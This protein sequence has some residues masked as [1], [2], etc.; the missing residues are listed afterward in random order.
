MTRNSIGG[1]FRDPNHHD[2]VYSSGGHREG[3]RV[4]NIMEKL[5]TFPLLYTQALVINLE[6]IPTN[7]TKFRWYFL[8]FLFK[9]LF[10]YFMYV[11]KKKASDLIAD[12]CE[13]SCGCWELNSGSLQGQPVLLTT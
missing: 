5:D 7:K 9:D 2:R 6:L 1:F 10:I 8:F 4:Y 3:H 11:E 12:G 13:P